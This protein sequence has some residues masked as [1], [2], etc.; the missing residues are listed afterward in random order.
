MD[1]NHED[2]SHWQLQGS[3]SGV[4]LPPRTEGFN[5]HITWIYS[6]IVYVIVI[7]EKN[8]DSPMDACRVYGSLTVNKVAGNFHI[9]A[10]K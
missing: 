7:R 5:W 4:S 2:S 6:K 3:R 8:L 1:S 10:G 9:T